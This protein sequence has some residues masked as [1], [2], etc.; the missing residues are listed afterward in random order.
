MS[1][2]FGALEIG[3]GTQLKVVGSRVSLQGVA[4][5]CLGFRV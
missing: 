4:L 2:G 1:S 5:F 3:F